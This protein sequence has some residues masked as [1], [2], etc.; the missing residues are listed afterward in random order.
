MASPRARDGQGWPI[1]AAGFRPFFLLAF[2]SLLSASVP[3]QR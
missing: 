2:G 3:G 1:L